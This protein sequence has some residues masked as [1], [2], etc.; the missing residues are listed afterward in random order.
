MDSAVL[1]ISV[2]EFCSETGCHI[3]L[4][5]SA[6]VQHWPGDRA[7]KQMQGRAADGLVLHGF[8]SITGRVHA[9]AA[10]GN[11]FLRNIADT[12]DMT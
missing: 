4:Q 6:G 2:F 9:R 10:P 1:A 7:S 11:L 3:D 8:I 12:C 5:E